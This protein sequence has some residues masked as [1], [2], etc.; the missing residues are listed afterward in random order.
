M[1][2]LVFKFEE[3]NFELVDSRIVSVHVSLVS[4]V[5]GLLTHLSR[6]HFE[7]LAL[8]VLKKKETRY[9]YTYRDGINLR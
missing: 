8:R 3:I 9:L 1:H 2:S 7:L 4:K 6:I 5:I